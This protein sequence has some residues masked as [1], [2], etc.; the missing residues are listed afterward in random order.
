MGEAAA[1]CTLLLQNGPPTGTLELAKATGLTLIAYEC[2]PNMGRAYQWNL[3]LLQRKLLSEWDWMIA[4][5]RTG[6]ETNCTGVLYM[7][8]LIQFL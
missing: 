4:P 1:P 2:K 8:K 7:P 3:G 5:S 6:K